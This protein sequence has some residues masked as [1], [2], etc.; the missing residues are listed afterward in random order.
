MNP[1]MRSLVDRIVVG[2]MLVAMWQ[3]ASW[4]LGEY[5]ASSPWGTASRFVAMIASGELPLHTMYTLQETLVGFL[6]GAPP[7]ILIPFLLR[8]HATARAIIEPYIVGAYGIPKLALAPL[9]IV[10]F[11]I[12]IGSKVALVASVGFFILFFNAM[13]GVSAIDP[14]LLATARIFGPTRRVSCVKSCGRAPRLI[15]SRASS[16]PCPMPSAALW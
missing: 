6:I 10:W 1:R 14:R 12:G 3:V 4:T 11:G 8:R 16:P 13:A 7:G 5:W 15:F 9:F 2:V